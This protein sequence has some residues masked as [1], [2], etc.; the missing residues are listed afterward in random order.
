LILRLILR[1]AIVA[2][3]LPL[4]VRLERY[5]RIV[6]FFLDLGDVITHAHKKKRQR[7]SF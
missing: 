1:L 2:M 7:L 4:L 3:W 5:D 6:S